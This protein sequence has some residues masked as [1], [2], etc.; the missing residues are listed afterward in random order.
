MTET[1]RKLPIKTKELELSGDYVG[2]FF[3]ARMNPPLGVFFDIASGDLQRIMNGITRI[4]IAWNFV[5]EEGTLLPKPDLEVVSNYITSEL[6][7]AIAN[8][9]LDEMTKVPPA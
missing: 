7:N 9:W 3:T 4:I 8:A 6:L 2:W 5:D 1:I